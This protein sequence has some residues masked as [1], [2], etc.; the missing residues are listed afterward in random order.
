MD[1]K[2]TRQQKRHLT[3]SWWNCV[4]QDMQFFCPLTETGFVI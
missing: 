2:G 1:V 3:K 4:T